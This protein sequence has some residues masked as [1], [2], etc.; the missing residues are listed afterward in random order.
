[1]HAIN[2]KH[3]WYRPAIT[4]EPL[5][6]C[7]VVVVVAA[8]LPDILLKFV[9]RTFFPQPVH[10]VRELE[11]GFGAGLIAHSTAAALANPDDSPSLAASSRKDF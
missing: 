7:Q 6:A 11:L 5:S 4:T 3:L 10:V 9:Y 2:S 8:L 1:L